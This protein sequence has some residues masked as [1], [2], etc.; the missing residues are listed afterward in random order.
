MSGKSRWEKVRQA[1]LL[2]LETDHSM[3]EAAQL[4]T[5]V[6]AFLEMIQ[7]RAC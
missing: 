7:E 1:P 4:G 3:E 2:H 5:R 6:Q